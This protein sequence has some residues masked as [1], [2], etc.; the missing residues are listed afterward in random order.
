MTKL[1]GLL[2]RRNAESVSSEQICSQLCSQLSAEAEDEDED[3][4][5]L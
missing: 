3:I 4:K 1:T 5:I 2:V